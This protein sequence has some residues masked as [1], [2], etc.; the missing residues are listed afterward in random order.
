MTRLQVCGAF[1]I[2]LTFLLS[3]TG[4]TA[5][6]ATLQKRLEPHYRLQRPPGPGPFAAVLLVPGCGGISAPRLQT[7]EQLVRDGYAVVFVD[8][9]ASRGLQTAC[10]GE[11][12]V[13]EVAQDIRA[14][15]AHLRS[16]PDIR[17]TGLGAVG[18]SWGGAGVLASLVVSGQDQQP[19]LNAAAAFY[20]V[21]AVLRPW[22]ANIPVLLLLGAL[23]DIAPPASCQA[24]ARSVGSAAPV[25]VHMYPNARHAFD[26][27][28]LPPTAPSRAFPGKTVGYDA[29]AARQA[30]GQVATQFDRQLRPSKEPAR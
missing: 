29:E 6:V 30:W 10:G 19:P 27:S 20:P 25:V 1:S 26:L 5:D 24:L 2:A 21:C 3:L 8:Y 22:Q 13:D 9:L 17:P 18:W 15:S 28:D 16:L 4:F 12:P 14:V 23:D 11:V 7:A